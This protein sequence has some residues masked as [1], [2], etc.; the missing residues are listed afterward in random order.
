M[1]KNNKKQLKITQ[2]RRRILNMMRTKPTLTMSGIARELG[3]RMNTVSVN[4]AQLEEAGLISRV[5]L[6]N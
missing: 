4:V 6:V 2:R 1:K 5:W 3:E